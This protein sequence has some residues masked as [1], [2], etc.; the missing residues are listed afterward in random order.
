MVDDGYIDVPVR[1]EISWQV[2]Q[3]PFV[4]VDV[5][6]RGPPHGIGLEHVAEQAHHALVQVVRDWENAGWKS[7]RMRVMAPAVADL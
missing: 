6:S 4:L 1:E 7:K 5:L 2:L 3:E